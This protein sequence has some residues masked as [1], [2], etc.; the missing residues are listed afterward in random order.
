MH[1]GSIS[2]SA[3]IA[4]ATGDTVTAIGDTKSPGRSNP[5]GAH[6]CLPTHDLQLAVKVLSA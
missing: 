1:P 3:G 4:T 6:F 5:A 2:L